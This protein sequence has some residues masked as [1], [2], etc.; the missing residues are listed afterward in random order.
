MEHDSSLPS[1]QQPAVPPRPERLS[2]DSNEITGTHFS[3]VVPRS[4]MNHNIIIWHHKLGSS[5]LRT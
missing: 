3:F 5:F 1:S 4:I 2:N